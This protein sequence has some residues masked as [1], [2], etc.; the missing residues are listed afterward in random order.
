MLVSKV[1]TFGGHI[2]G[3]GHIRDFTVRIENMNQTSQFFRKQ[4]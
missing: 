4:T 2:F 1:L 3:G